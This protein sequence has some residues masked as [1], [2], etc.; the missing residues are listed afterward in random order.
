VVESINDLSSKGYNEVVL[1]GV[2][3][4]FF[5]RDSGSGTF[6]DVLRRIENECEIGRIRLSSI[7]INEVCDEMLELIAGS[8]KFC[9]H[10]HL[11]LQSGDDEILRN[12][13]RRYSSG[14]FVERVEA[15]QQ[16]I[17]D[18]GITTDVIVGFPGETDEQFDRTVEIVNTLGFVKLHVFRFSPRP[19][20]MAS[21]MDSRVSPNII[22]SRAKSLIKLGEQA[23][24]R[25]RE[26]FVGKT[27]HV[28]TES[29]T[30]NGSSCVGLSSNYIRVRLPGAS[31]D[32]VNRILPVQLVE[33]GTGAGV[34]VGRLVETSD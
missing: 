19:G 8:D 15:I 3:L 22:S 5:G 21:K 2:H 18:I 6:L 16:R 13:G 17:P 12:M 31:A 33:S 34:A 25:F 20:T 23:A 28:L 4:G 14:F 32:C 24:V 9:R 10:L 26:R 7:E 11:P 1:T 30:N 29:W 27:V